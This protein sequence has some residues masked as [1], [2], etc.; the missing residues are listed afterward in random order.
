[1]VF[2]TFLVQRAMVVGPAI[3]LTHGLMARTIGIA[4][5]VGLA[6]HGNC[7]KHGTYITHIRI[8]YPF[9]RAERVVNNKK[10]FRTSNAFDF[11]AAREP[12]GTRTVF[13]VIRHSTVGVQPARALPFARVVALPL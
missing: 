9:E 10:K 13:D 1:M 5:F 7:A 12:G 3:G 6:S 2:E 11:A 8:L 4:V